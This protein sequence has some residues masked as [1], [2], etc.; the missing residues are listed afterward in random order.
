LVSSLVLLVLDLYTFV[1]FV[2]VVLSWLRLSPDN[3]VVRVVT[4]VTEPVLAPIRKLLPDLGG[5]DFSPLILLVILQ[6]LKRLFGGM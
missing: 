2:A 6:V 4:T 5:F 3:P 1:V